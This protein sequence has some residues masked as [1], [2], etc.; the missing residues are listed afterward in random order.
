MKVTLAMLG[1]EEQHID[2]IG[3]LQDDTKDNVEYFDEDTIKVVQ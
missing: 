2:D 3:A 1:I